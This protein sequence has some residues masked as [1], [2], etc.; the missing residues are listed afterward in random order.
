MRARIA[1]IKSE[2]RSLADEQEKRTAAA[3]AERAALALQQTANAQYGASLDTLTDKYK[4]QLDVRKKTLAE[5]TAELTRARAE[6]KSIETEFQNLVNTITQPA[7]GDVFLL[8]VFEAIRKSKFA[9]DSGEIE[10]SIALARQGGDL[11]G[12]L[13]EKGTET[14]GTLGFLAKQL[15]TV[16][17]EAAKKR[18]S[19]ELVDKTAAQNAVDTLSAQAQILKDT[20][21]AAGSE[22]ARAF[23]EAMAAEFAATTLPAPQV[24]APV[25]ST[26][27]VLTAP[28]GLPPGVVRDGNSFTMRADVEARGRK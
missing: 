28:A 13:K 24:A 20:A 18:T 17:T 6:Q 27:G 8:D 5:E 11:L 15:Q 4:L 3:E 22:Y 21:P 1:E 9:L 2:L 16:A 23:L 19:T 7:Q 10:Q 14:Q 25:V 12:Q 26:E